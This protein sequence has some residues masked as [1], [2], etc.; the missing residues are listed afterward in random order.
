M[1]LV[2]GP[3][4]EKSGRTPLSMLWS[5]FTADEQKS[6]DYAIRQLSGQL[7]AGTAAVLLFIDC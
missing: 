7:S 1:V 4:A 3:I 2:A 6:N 5:A